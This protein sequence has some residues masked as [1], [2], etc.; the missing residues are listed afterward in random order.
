[1]GAEY[2]A[3]LRDGVILHLSGSRATIIRFGVIV[4]RGTPRRVDHLD[5]P[6]SLDERG[7]P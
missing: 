5:Y 3:I 4:A 1:M 6:V 7:V 2:S